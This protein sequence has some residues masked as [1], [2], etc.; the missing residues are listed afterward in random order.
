M[1]APFQKRDFYR[2]IE[3]Y[4][5]LDCEILEDESWRV[6]TRHPMHYALYG[7]YRFHIVLL[8]ILDHFDLSGAT[9]LDLGPYPG[10]FLRLLRHLGPSEGLRLHGAGLRATSTFVSQ[11]ERDCNASILEVNLDPTNP[12]LLSRNFPSTIPM[13]E[14]T[15]D[16][17]HAGEIIEHLINPSWMLQESYRL[18]K[19]GGSI[20]ITTPNITRIGNVFKLL[21]GRSNYDRCSPIGSQ[22]PHD[23]WRR[24]FH[25]YEL[26]ELATLM[27]EHGFR[28]T[29]SAHYNSRN[30][31]MV[32]KSWK[33][34]VIDLAK[35]PFYCVPHLKCSLFLVATKP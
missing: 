21:I 25:E 13:S 32:V 35:V 23:E 22:D 4:E 9:F 27:S 12:D 5:P 33:Q 3:G 6:F 16:Y 19:S 11:M 24:H 29:H 17:I 7:R 31:E 26:K 28:V 10:T 1:N 18:L 8:Y 34:R 15:V 2:L 30:T 14:N 20:I